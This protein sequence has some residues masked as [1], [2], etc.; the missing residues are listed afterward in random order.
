M[1][2]ANGEQLELLPS[3]YA[4]ELAKMKMVVLARK[5]LNEVFAAGHDIDSMTV[6]Q[7]CMYVV[8]AAL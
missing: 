3:G 7:G 2:P 5:A 4:T 6:A 8:A 1:D